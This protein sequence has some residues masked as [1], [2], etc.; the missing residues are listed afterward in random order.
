MSLTVALKGIDGL[1]LAAD[2]RATKGYTLNGPNTRDDSNKF[3]RLNDYC[4]ALTYG[5]SNIGNAGITALRRAVAKDYNHSMSMDLILDKGVQIFKSVSSDWTKRN[6][7]IKRMDK[8]VGFFLAGYERAEK[9][10]RIFNF[11]SPEF[12][13]IR[14]GSGS[15]LAGQ[16]HIAKFLIDKLYT[17]DMQIRRLKNLAVLLLSET[18]TVEKTVGGQI[19]LAAI[20]KS[21]GFQWVS[22]EEIKSI[23]YKNELFRN[24][25]KQHLYL[26]LWSVFNN[27]PENTTREDV[28][29]CR[30][31]LTN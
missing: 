25:F 7:E 26:A 24:L 28:I 10:F 13:P 15:L 18:M 11:Q 31:I 16:W 22:E 9:D 12:S 6:P 23:I 30:Q 3:I 14:L 27:D 1:V 17:D 5:L 19:H 8:D 20:T 2:S 21:K 4:G 29:K